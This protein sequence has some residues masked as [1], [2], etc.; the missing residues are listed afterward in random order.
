MLISRASAQRADS[1]AIAGNKFETL[2]RQ[3][4]QKQCLAFSA[5]TSLCLRD[6]A[7]PVSHLDEREDH[8]S[9]IATNGNFQAK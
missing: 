4:G 2:F 8:Q 9:L 7:T 6:N 1:S 5:Q 3:A